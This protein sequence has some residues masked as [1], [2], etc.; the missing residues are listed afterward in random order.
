MIENHVFVLLSPS[1]IRS[2][3]SQKLEVPS[4]TIVMTLTVKLPI[5]VA[6]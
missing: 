2:K 1:G 5:H 4:V 3:F 6:S